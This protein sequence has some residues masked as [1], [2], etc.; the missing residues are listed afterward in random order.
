MATGTI[1]I[2]IGGV[3]SG[4]TSWAENEALG[5]A[6]KSGVNPIY[7]ASGVAFDREMNQRIKRHQND[8]REQNWTTIE[9]PIHVSQVIDQ[10]TVGGVVVWDCLT[11]WLTNEMME[12]KKNGSVSIE[13]S[14]LHKEIEQFITWAR[15]NLTSL[16]IISNEV[17]NEHISQ[18]GMTADYQRLIGALHQSL[19]STCDIAI[20]MESGLPLVRKGEWFN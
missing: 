11:T 9:Q 1:I 20:E 3:R 6:H 4:K 8:R 17:L 15:S 13:L 19:V 2:V 12:H 14:Y 16:L 18:N 5:L 10:L 7:L